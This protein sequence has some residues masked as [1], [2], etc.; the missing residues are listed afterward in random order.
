MDIAAKDNYRNAVEDLRRQVFEDQSAAY[1]KYDAGRTSASLFHLCPHLD[2][3]EHPRLL[4]YIYFNQRRAHLDQYHLELLVP[5][6][7]VEGDGAQALFSGQPSI[8][9]SYHY[10]AYRLVLPY[11]LSRGLKIS[12]LIDHRV[13]D[14]QGKDFDAILGAFCATRGLPS[15]NFRIRDTANPTM[16]LSLVRDIRAGFTVLVF[17]DGNIGAGQD[18][19]EHFTPLPFLGAT[20][21]S[22][23][24]VAVVSHLAKCPIIPVLAPR[25]EDALWGTR[26]QVCAPI[27]PDGQDRETYAARASGALWTPLE[28]A[29]ADAPLPWESWRYVDRSLDIAALEARHPVAVA[30]TDPDAV[31]FNA[32]RFV[33][34]E[35]E[36]SPV[37]F[38]RVN[39][40]VHTISSILFQFLK[41][42][43]DMPRSRHY[44]LSQ[45]KMNEAMWR[46]LIEMGVLQ[47]VSS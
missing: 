43:L 26:F 1:S 19:S 2:T 31:V 17:V 24:G 15:E 45:P 41:Q 16:L 39:Y 35:G 25:D 37:L 8:V 10:G 30:D 9:C 6:V 32:R 21:R 44:A 42:F 38:D 20:L 47:G 40:R 4:R 33:L 13:A 28:N 34:D 27:T 23:V 22:R 12:M 18:N 36:S 7:S 46:K 14:A 29:I 11:L 5:N 3:A